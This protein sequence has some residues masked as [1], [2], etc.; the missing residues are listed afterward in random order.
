MLEIWATLYL[1]SITYAQ[2]TLPDMIISWKQMTQDWW[3]F[4][5]PDFKKKVCKKLPSSNDPWRITLSTC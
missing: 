3:R 5:I 4:K 1:L 2:H